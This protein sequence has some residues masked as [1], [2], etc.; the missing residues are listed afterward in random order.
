MQK[1][2]TNVTGFQLWKKSNL[3]FGIVRRQS[4]CQNL[5]NGVADGIRTRNSNPYVK[6]CKSLMFQIQT[7]TIDTTECGNYCDS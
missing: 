3:M 4:P 7:N 6:I 2:F 5:K 1:C